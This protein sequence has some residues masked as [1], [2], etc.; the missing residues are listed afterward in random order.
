[1]NNV[2]ETKAFTVK[3]NPFF[4]VLV[5]Y[6]IVR[7]FCIIEFAP[8][9]DEVNYTQ[10]SQLI[11]ADWEANKYIS[12]DGRMAHQYKDPFQYWFGALFLDFLDNPVINLRICSLIFGLVGFIFSYL[13][14]LKI[15]KNRTAAGIVG[16][17]IVFSDYFSMMDSIFL[18]EVFV[19]G[20]G[21]AFLYFSYV[22]FEKIYSGRSP[23]INAGFASIFFLLALLSK[24]SGIVW[25]VFGFVILGIFWVSNEY[26]KQ[27]QIKRTVYSI[28]LLLI[29]S[30]TGKIIYDL[31]IPSQYVLL[32]ESGAQARNNTFNL[33]GLLQFPVEKWLD[34]AKFYFH[35][36][37][38][39]EVFWFWLI[40]V[41]LFSYFVLRKQIRPKWDLLMMLFVGWIVS[42][43]PFVFIMK[44]R[45]IRHFGMGMCFFYFLIGYI[46]SLVFFRSKA[47]KVTGLLLL[48]AFLG[49]RLYSS[50]IP[51][52]K[53]G[54]TDLAIIE[55]KPGWPSGIGI[56]EMIEKVKNLSSGVLIYDPQWGHPGTSLIVFSKEFPQLKLVPA[57][58]NV[59]AKIGD[60]Y[61]FAKARGLKMHFVYDTRGQNDHSW[62]QKI[63][64]DHML[65]AKKEIIQKEYRGKIFDNSSIA[66]CT[67][68]F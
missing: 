62:R 29:I 36:L 49:L 47:T 11:K 68:G 48:S 13:L 33:E 12:M 28:V 6:L 27:R 52:L 41:A 15:F 24:Q 32:R 34:G 31:I 10:F 3:Y 5:F 53:Y 46:S 8:H 25:F 51:L 50:Y 67:A 7:I 65:C 45:Y 63:L 57:N 58:P 37:L 39:T 55:T 35:N 38:F 66:I 18:T 23:W 56:N 20:S 40:P 26:S 59:L 17:M 21:T 1:M 54:Q 9:N 60:I 22:T 30:L 4:V 43:L 14:A 2:L 61:G 64:E 19:Y 44:S 16:L 42:F